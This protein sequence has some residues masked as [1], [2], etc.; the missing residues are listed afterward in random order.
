LV[1]KAPELLISER[2]SIGTKT[3]SVGVQGVINFVQQTPDRVR[4]NS[5]TQVGQFRAD[6]A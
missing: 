4:T 3:F 6:I 2:A 1:V 5:Q